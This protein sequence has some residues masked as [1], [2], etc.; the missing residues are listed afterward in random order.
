VVGV[1]SFASL[2]LPFCFP[3]TKT[4]NL[5]LFRAQKI[6][7]TMSGDNPQFEYVVLGGAET[8]IGSSFLQLLMSAAVR[9]DAQA[10]LM[11]GLYYSQDGVER[12]L[13]RSCRFSRTAADLG[14]VEAQVL[15]AGAYM[16]GKGVP[17]DASEALRYYRLAAD[18]GHAEAQRSLATCLGQFGRK[19]AHCGG[20]GVKQDGLKYCS[21]CKTVAYC[22]LAHQ[23]AHWTTHKS[24]CQSQRR[25]IPTSGDK[26]AARVEGNGTFRHEQA[27]LAVEKYTAAIAVKEVPNYF[28]NRAAAFQV[29]HDYESALA[30]CEKAIRLL[31]NFGAAYTG[32]GL[33]HEALGQVR[34]AAAA[35][36]QAHRLE[37]DNATGETI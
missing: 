13:A 24:A 11:I 30:D 9:G 31:P 1:L 33:A 7:S 34:E 12:D 19:C 18:Q 14:N 32:K 6:K 22:S 25:A 37:S 3:H 29:L 21:G 2:L 28:V 20:I 4:N 23:R 26:T 16:N 27:Q 36:D 10:N 35:R 17:R 15:V 5:T 8:Q